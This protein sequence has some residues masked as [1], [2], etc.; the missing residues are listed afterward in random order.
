MDT[1]ISSFKSLNVP[2]SN[3]EFELRFK[4]IS[5]DIF[6]GL[7]ETIDKNPL[8]T[9]KSLECSINAIS[10]NIY[11]KK[12][13]HEESYIRKMTFVA[14]VKKSEEYYVKRRIGT[15][16]YINDFIKYSLAIAEEKP[17]NKFSTST[18]A[19]VRIK[20]R[21]SYKYENWRIDLT[22]IKQ[23]SIMALQTELGNIK[24]AIFTKDLTADTFMQLDFNLIDHYELEA[25]WIGSPSDISSESVKDVAGKIFAMINPEYLSIS[26]Y[27]DVISDVSKLIYEKHF[28]RGKL[29]LKSVT[30]Q[31][32]ALSRNMYYSEVYPPDGYYLTEKADG[33]RCIA[34]VDENRCRL[35]ADKITTIDSAENHPKTIIDCELIGDKVYAFD[36]MMAN[37][38]RLTG[39]YSERI[40]ELPAACEIVSKFTPCQP[41]N[42]VLLSRDQ[43]Q[44]GFDSVYK[45]KYPYAIDGLILTDPSH[46]YAHTKNYKW[47]PVSH[48][49]IDFLAVLCPKKLI[50]QEPYIDHK[51]RDLYLLFVGIDH[52]MR[53]NLGI[54]LIANYKH[55]FDTVGDYYPIQF[56]P[57]I[58]KYAYL[59]W[60]DPALGDINYKVVELKKTSKEAPWEYVRMRTDRLYEVN[61]YGNDFRIAELTYMNYIDIFNYED[62]YNMN[63]GYFAK[64]ASDLYLGSNKYKRFVISIL[65]K[66]L[67]TNAAWVIDLAAGRGADLHRYQEVGVHNALFIDIDSSAIAELIKRKFDMYMTK[68]KRVQK[69]H[70]ATEQTAVGQVQ[71][72]TMVIHT[73][74]QDLSAPT[75]ALVD[76]S[77][78]IV[79]PST[80]DGIVCNF[81]IHYMCDTIEH[82]RSLLKYV[83][84]M[85]K[86][87]GIFLFTTFNGKK[88]F[89]MLSNIEKGKSVDLIED[90]RIKYS[91]MKL[92]SG[93]TMSSVGQRIA[94][95]L[96]FTDEMREEPL[97]NIDM[98]ISEG[99]K[100]GLE[101]EL[102]ESFTNM[103][104][105]FSSADKVLY[106]KIS[107]SDKE[108]I[109]LHQ[110]VS[111]RRIK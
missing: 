40:K 109:G 30:N 98:I 29:G 88:I 82:I 4:S 22:A 17:V 74:V 49:T 85:L 106:D 25:E 81:A 73:L 1:A 52:K 10:K 83:Q 7:V 23:S 15:S 24:D 32:I 84:S 104:P 26:Q 54:S 28:Y 14:G 99:K 75:K 93:N 9:D 20:A 12:G 57:S 61:Y 38:K 102:C 53:E 34:Y 51:G 44:E 92:Y 110:Y 2:G 59:Y 8:F 62:L 97:A 80:V 43:L 100:L 16:I 66:Q 64:T 67:F 89:E 95:K 41:K 111:M 78:N 36:C 70:E 58:D 63:T 76:A 21:L 3:I 79:V 18:N 47:K 11:E 103:M 33:V 5:R 50:G 86:V 6:V 35:I 105:L 69:W 19:L 46:E 108:Y 45:A 55:M 68:R 94:V 90:G 101:Y 87:G 37:G 42:I 77:S 60:H 13:K 31:V 96:P 65:I 39:T 56:S 91:I 48:N 27:Q 107:E 72:H 71:N